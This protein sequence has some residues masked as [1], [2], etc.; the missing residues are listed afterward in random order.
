MKFLISGS[1]TAE[2]IRGLVREG[3][4]SRRRHFEQNVRAVGGSVEAFYYAFGADDLYA[5]V[6]LPSEA[7]AVA[8]TVGISAGG[9]FIA[10]T[11]MLIEPEQV[12]EAVKKDIG[13]RPPGA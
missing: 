10:R 4:S 12:D 8:L 13:Y 6:D 9:A 2:G 1:Y 3:G 11:T 7:E 5:I